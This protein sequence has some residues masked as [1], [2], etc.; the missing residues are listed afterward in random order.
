MGLEPFEGHEVVETRV[1]VTRAGDGLSTAMEIDPLELSIGQT[2][3]VALDCVVA[4]VKF[5]PIK[6]TDGYARVHTLRAGG[7]AIVPRSA[8]A[9][10]LDE[11]AQKIE[12]AKGVQRLDLEDD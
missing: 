12:A 11:Q 4:Q 9:K 6:D 10:A 3:T 2:V 7:A 1:A 8:V 5:E